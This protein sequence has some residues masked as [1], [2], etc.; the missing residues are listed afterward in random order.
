M[1]EQMRYVYVNDKVD[2]HLV[3]AFDRWCDG[4]CGEQS[5]DNWIE[6]CSLTEID[7]EPSSMTEG[8]LRRNN[9]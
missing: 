2:E 3:V 7:K 5:E 9:E 1:C 8:A 6:C 4:T